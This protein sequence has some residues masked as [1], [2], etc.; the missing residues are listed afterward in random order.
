MEIARFDHVTW[1]IFVSI[2][3]VINVARFRQY[4]DGRIDSLHQNISRSTVSIEIMIQTNVLDVL[5][6]AKSHL[7]VDDFEIRNPLVTRP[8]FNDNSEMNYLPFGMRL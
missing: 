5:H 6:A 7:N 8:T 2:Q 4:D 1:L 3:A